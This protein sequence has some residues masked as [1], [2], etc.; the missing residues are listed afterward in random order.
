MQLGPGLA[1]CPFA[2]GRPPS[3]RQGRPSR[4]G[5]CLL[6]PLPPETVLSL[7]VSVDRSQW[8]SER[9]LGVL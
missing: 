2:W 8:T 1:L 3:L 5:G 6:V 4:A 9:S 7:A